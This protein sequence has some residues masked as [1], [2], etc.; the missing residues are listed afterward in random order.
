MDKIRIRGGRPLEGSI[1]VSGA[2]N[3]ALPDLAAALLT[4]QPLVLRNVPQVRDVITMT[5]LLE[6]LGART[7]VDREGMCHVQVSRMSEPEAPYDLVRTMRASVL[8]LGPLVARTGWARVSLPGGC[9][10][11]ERP[12]DLHLDALS[13]MGADVELVHGYVTARSRRL[14]GADI[15]FATRTV[16]GTENLMMAATLA[17][18]RT[19][20]RHCAMEPEIVDLA[21]LLTA[22]GAHITGAGTETIQIEGVD[23]L[24]GATHGVI[25]DRVEAGTFLIA[26]AISRGR[27]EV[28]ECD[29]GHLAALVDVLER[30]GVPLTTGPGRM[31]AGPWESLGAHDIVTSTYPG[32]AT[33]LQAQYM[34]LMTQASGAAVITENIF[35]NRFMHAGELRRMGADITL[36][37]R[38]AIVRGP[39]KLSGAPLMATDLRASASLILAALAADGESTINRVYHIDRGYERIE[40]KLRALGAEIER[41]H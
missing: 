30:C 12:I 9:A 39:T 13:R 16:T 3:A 26:G 31:E 21:A 7:S 27:V 17:E 22:M 35:E 10:I 24:H 28:T 38:T 20:L 15:T 18:G 33:D 40:E 25:P 29:P 1:A 5:R 37:G 14:R 32:F 41:M 36:E 11:G 23:S 4:D 19:V 8:V 2:K 34:A 6:H